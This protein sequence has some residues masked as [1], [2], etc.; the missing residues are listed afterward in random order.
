M[1]ITMI[2]VWPVTMRL[3]YVP[4]RYF[5]K[6]KFLADVEAVYKQQGYVVIAACEG[7]K[8]TDGSLVAAY[9]DSIN[10]D[11]FG[12]PELGGLGQYLVDLV[13]SELNLKTRLDKP[14]TMQRVSG[15]CISGVDAH[16]AYLVGRDA[17]RH[18]VQGTSGYMVTLVREPGE[19]YLCTTG[20]APLQKVARPTPRLRHPCRASCAETIEPLAWSGRNRSHPG[21]TRTDL[22]LQKLRNHGLR[23]DGSEFQGLDR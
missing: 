2:E 11:A 19:E 16:E 17:V 21:Q 23:S 7:L 14:G 13:M 18:V 5:N 15:L 4:E 20:L 3:I 12:H 10:V 22:C 6:D 1:K 9:R 8:N